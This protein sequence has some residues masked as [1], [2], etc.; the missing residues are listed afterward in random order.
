MNISRVPSEGSTSSTQEFSS[1]A[2]IN[3]G[4]RIHFLGTGVL[5]D[6]KKAV[7]SSELS[8]KSI[9]PTP[10]VKKE[11]VQ[12]MRIFFSR[13]STPTVEEQEQANGIIGAKQK[14]ERQVDA[15]DAHARKMQVEEKRLKGPF[16]SSDSLQ[17]ATIQ[18]AELNTLL[19][20]AQ[21][22]LDDL[23]SQKETT[24]NLAD[25]YVWYENVPAQIESIQEHVSYLQGRAKVSQALI[26]LERS[27][28]AYGKPKDQPFE[29][30][31][32][33]LE[34]KNHLISVLKEVIERNATLKQDPEIQELLTSK[35]LSVQAAYKII[36]IAYPG[37]KGHVERLFD[38]ISSAK[39]QR[40]DL[41]K[42]KTTALA[43]LAEQYN[44]KANEINELER[45]LYHPTTFDG[46]KHPFTKPKDIEKQIAQAKKE[47][48]DIYDVLFTKGH[49][50]L[51]EN[52]W[53]KELG[54]KHI[55]YQA[56]N[57]H[58]EAVQQ[59]LSLIEER[60]QISDKT[61]QILDEFKTYEKEAKTIRKK[62]N[63]QLEATQLRIQA[64][65]KL[66]QEIA[67]HFQELVS[68]VR[69]VEKKQTRQE[70]PA[71]SLNSFE[72]LTQLVVAHFPKL[73]NRFKKIA[74]LIEDHSFQREVTQFIQQKEVPASKT[75]QPAFATPVVT[76]R[77][78]P[79]SPTV[80]I[81]TG[82]RRRPLPKT[83][84]QHR[85]TTGNMVPV[86]PPILPFNPL[87]RISG[88]KP[89][90]KTISAPHLGPE[91]QPQPIVPETQSAPPSPVSRRIEE[92][93]SVIPAVIEK[94]NS[95][96]ET[97]EE[98]TI[99]QDPPS[100]ALPPRPTTTSTLEAKTSQPTP[101]NSTTSTIPK[102]PP[103][104]LAK[105]EK[106][107]ENT[108]TEP[109]KN[110]TTATATSH[111]PPPAEDSL[112]T[113]LENAM[114]ARRINLNENESTTE[115]DEEWV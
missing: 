39:D 89:L 81:P 17:K 99:N 83:P 37:L 84:P 115:D 21:S 59:P 46:I 91:K 14:L 86:L 7:N 40:V 90:T 1:P 57:Q 82:D 108:T 78:P 105:H 95:T 112:Q 93:V 96:F 32:S 87:N 51:Q 94:L 97:Q 63:P 88:T 98:Q 69:L 49:F 26:M 47:F 64:Q 5:D 62:L 68:T 15:I 29:Q 109:S 2:A 76:P 60:Q 52:A 6:S 114:K 55:A 85:T 4:E 92:G 27:L 54:N 38:A 111:T 61:S 13:Y 16:P 103:R 44:K 100:P 23:E 66:K 8:S 104:P 72:S 45:R 42:A 101:P 31:A 30:F 9:S 102:P 43:H 70:I 110:K 53:V 18:Q 20:K 77:S 19:V 73:E 56:L 28:V 11:F 36:S 24:K 75:P 74:Q 67:S 33:I 106:P 48:K 35:D 71:A 58:I 12:K 22:M 113:I 65:V 80:A 41:L 3:Q 79:R 107:S 50:D 10:V 34:N 25:A